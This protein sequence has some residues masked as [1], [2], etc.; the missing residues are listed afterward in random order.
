VVTGFLLTA[1][2]NWTGRL[3]IKGAPL[4]L[5]VVVWAAGRFA[6]MFSAFIGWFPAAIVDVAFLALVAAAVAREILA[7]RNRGNLKVLVIPAVLIAANVAFHLEA[8]AWGAA[9]YGIRLGLAA[10]IMPMTIIGGRIVPSFTRNL[11]REN[12]GRLPVPFGRFDVGILVLSGV[13]APA[14]Q[15]GNSAMISL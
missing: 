1:I 9:D 15:A 2:P 8:H 13:G 3:P 14:R 10:A 11:A 5:L 6:V 4:L 12:P 7:S